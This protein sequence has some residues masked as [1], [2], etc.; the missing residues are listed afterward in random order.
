MIQ[1]TKSANTATK[2]AL[3][4]VMDQEPTTVLFAKMFVMV[5][6]AFGNVQYLNITRAKSANL[7]MKTVL[8]VA[9]V[10]EIPLEKVDATPVKRPLLA[11]MIR[12]W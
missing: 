7:V 5:H 8:E 3:E 6:T 10:Q 9:V 1:E 11:C 4:H 2:S 12:M